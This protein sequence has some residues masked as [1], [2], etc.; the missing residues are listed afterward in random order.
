MFMGK[1]PHE[2]CESWTV[3]VAPVQVDVSVGL[4]GKK[5]GEISA[6]LIVNE[7]LNLF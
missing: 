2:L 5:P 1:G 4:K 3:P 7:Q 6:P